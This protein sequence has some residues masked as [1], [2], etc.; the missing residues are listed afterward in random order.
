MCAARWER[1]CASRV[2]PS[3]PSPAALPRGPQLGGARAGGTIC[4]PSAPLAPSRA[5]MDA[6]GKESRRP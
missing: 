5:R 3:A 2:G 6:D 4:A 1:W